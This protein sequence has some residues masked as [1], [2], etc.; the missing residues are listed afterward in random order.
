MFTR[1]ELTAVTNASNF[2]S[3]FNTVRQSL[4]NFRLRQAAILFPGA[5]D[6]L[7]QFTE[8]VLASA[9]DWPRTDRTDLCRIAAE[10]SE[11][12]GAN[13]EEPDLARA[14]RL[15]AALL[16]ELAELPALA[17]SVLNSGDMAEYL[18]SFFKRQGVFSHLNGAG[19][20]NRSVHVEMQAL[21]ELAMIDDAI[22]FEDLAQGRRAF[23]TG[24]SAELRSIADIASRLSQVLPLGLSA[25]EI[26]GFS[27]L[28]HERT[29]RSTL[30][31]VEEALVP[32]LRSMAF[33]LELLPGKR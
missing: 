31:S 33:P 17:S 21:G 12:L 27:A 19:T 10:I 29:R 3:D 7:M 4:V 18:L 20:V 2:V 30:L 16:Y 8:A 14:F 5:E 13:S 26:R 6:R 24:A 32:S 23:R 22:E 15:R 25:S 11:A 1:E 9:I 28:V